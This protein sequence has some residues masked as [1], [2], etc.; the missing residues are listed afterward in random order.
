MTSPRVSEFSIEVPAKW[1]LTGEHT[2][3]RGGSA[4]AFPHPKFSLKLMFREQDSFSITVNPFQSQI[5]QLIGRACEFLNK[6]TTLFSKGEISIESQIPIGAGLGS[7]AALSV[8]MA[9]LAIWRT[10][11]NVDLWIPLATHLEDLFHGKSSGMDVSVIAHSQPIFF[12]MEKRAELLPEF[13][14]FPKFE[15]YDSKMETESPKRIGA[16]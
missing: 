5:K 11:S 14:R 9:R 10:G 13:K 1:V 8:A 4:I 3:L 6:E 15:L 7:S 16:S 12:S 2:V